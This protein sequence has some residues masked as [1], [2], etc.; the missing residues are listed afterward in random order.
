[1]GVEIELYHKMFAGTL[2]IKLSKSLAELIVS[3]A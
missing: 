1:M 3:R 2:V